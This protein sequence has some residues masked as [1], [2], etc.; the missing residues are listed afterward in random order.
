MRGAG[1]ERT[2]QDNGKNERE[3]QTEKKDKNE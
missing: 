3:I 2:R 1:T